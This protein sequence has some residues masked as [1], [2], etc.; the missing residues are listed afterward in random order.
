MSNIHIWTKKPVAYNSLDH[1]QP[2]GTARD[3]STNLMFNRKLRWWIPLSQ[4]NVLDL[5]CAG[6]GFVKSILDDSGFAV[7]IEGSDYSKV[8]KRAEW[9]T[10][11]EYLFTADIT[12]P[13]KL[14]RTDEKK[15]EIPLMFNVITAWEVMEHISEAKLDAVARNICSHLYSNGV[16][17]MSISPNEEIIEGVALHQIVENKDWWVAKFEELG[18]VHHQEVLSYF[19]VDYVRGEEN[20][21]SSFH[22]ILTRFGESVPYKK[23]LNLLMNLVQAVEMVADDSDEFPGYKTVDSI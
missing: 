23:K 16:V 20:A 17:I 2:W 10:I 1:T 8:R 15:Q 9:G 22:L 18:L 6:G 4:L 13:F 3:N 19:G 12:E 7:G 11:P 14:Y 21:P 5:G